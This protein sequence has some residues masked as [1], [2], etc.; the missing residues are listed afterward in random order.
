MDLTTSSNHA[1]QSEPL[2]DGVSS[3]QNLRELFLTIREKMRPKELEPYE[4]R[5]W[6]MLDED[7]KSM[8]DCLY[9]MWSELQTLKG[10]SLT[11][12]KRGIHGKRTEG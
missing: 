6:K 3:P 7:Q 10:G 5:R 1:L 2:N 9:R 8:W 4:Y 12:S 11:P